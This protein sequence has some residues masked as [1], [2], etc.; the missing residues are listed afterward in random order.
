MNHE[1]NTVQLKLRSRK[2]FK[3]SLR[4]SHNI[5]SLFSHRDKSLLIASCHGFVQLLVS[6]EFSHVFSKPYLVLRFCVRL[7]QNNLL[8]RHLFNE[9]VHISVGISLPILFVFS[10]FSDFICKLPLAA[11]N[12][13]GKRTLKVILIKLKCK[14]SCIYYSFKILY[15]LPTA[16]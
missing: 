11:A 1:T 6:V 4:F 13:I 10:F 9:Q 3:I 5:S 14:Q 16:S 12:L 7:K 2:H 8:Q 15:L